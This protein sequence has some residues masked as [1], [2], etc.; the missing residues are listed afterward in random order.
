MELIQRS[1]CHRQH[2]ARSGSRP[3]TCQRRHPFRLQ[4][5]AFRLVYPLRQCWLN[6]SLWRNA[7]APTGSDLPV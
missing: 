5:G 1:S 7:A 2:F 3:P 4:Q 6:S